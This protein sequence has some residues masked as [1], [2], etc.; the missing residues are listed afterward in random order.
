MGTREN[1]LGESVQ[2]RNHSLCFGSKIRKIRLFLQTSVFLYKSGVQGVIH[3]MY[4]LLCCM[5]LFSHNVHVFPGVAVE[6]GTVMVFSCKQS[7]WEDGSGFRSERVI[8]QA[9]PDQDLF[10]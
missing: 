10:S 5:G 4:M 9:D 7:C 8:V 3:Y 6:F 1:C 2:T